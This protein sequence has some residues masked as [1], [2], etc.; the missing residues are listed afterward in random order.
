MPSGVD[1]QRQQR[2]RRRFVTRRQT[3]RP[4]YGRRSPAPTQGEEPPR[5]PHV[6]ILRAHVVDEGV[7]RL[8]LTAGT[9]Q[10]QKWR[11]P[12]K[13]PHRAEAAHACRGSPAMCGCAFTAVPTRPSSGADCHSS[14]AVNT[15]RP[16]HQPIGMNIS[17]PHPKPSPTTAPLT[18]QRTHHTFP[19]LGH[20]A[21]RQRPAN[22]VVG[23]RRPYGRRRKQNTIMD[24]SWRG[25]S[26][27]HPL[28]RLGSRSLGVKKLAAAGR[29]H[30]RLQ[31]TTS[32]KGR[33]SG[34]TSGRSG[35]SAG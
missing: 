28:C 27:A 15:S 23:S 10:D 31:C 14:D 17:P 5:D 35:R 6:V 8:S 16:S 9:M 25:V 19:S 21:C 34:L 18:C 29:S 2:R 11:E 32:W 24:R 12:W 7:G 3:M 4:R 13:A 26:Q 20:P 30:Q 33:R 1:R 22:P